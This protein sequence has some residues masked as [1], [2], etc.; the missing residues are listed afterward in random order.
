ME[1]ASRSSTV[2]SVPIV[3]HD[4][5]GRRVGDPVGER[6]VL[7]GVGLEHLEK[8]EVGVAGVFDVVAEGAGDI[9]DIARDELVGPGAAVTAEHGHARIAFQVVLPQLV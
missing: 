3:V 5:F 2:S 9:A 4:E 7:V 6:E 1:N 8:D